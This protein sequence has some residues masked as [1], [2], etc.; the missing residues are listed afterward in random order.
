M[1]ISKFNYK[2][3]NREILNDN[4]RYYVTP[5]GEQVP[6]VTTILDR[7]KP[8]EARQALAEWRKRV[9]QDKAQ[10]ITTEAANRG[11]RMHKWLENY[12]QTGVLGIP[13]TH[14]ESQRS[15]RMAM[16]IIESGLKNVSEIWGN[17]VSL[18]F[19]ELYAG[20]TD[21]VGIHAGD[22]AILDFKQSNKPKRREWIDD[23]FLQLTAYALAH[24]EVHGTNI[25]K[26]V[27]MMAVSLPRGD[28]PEYQEFVLEPTDFDMWTQ[29][30]CD[31]VSEYYR[32]R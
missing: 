5:T 16:K 20:T 8:A 12:V 29:R 7:T 32:I 31:R 6:S 24:N 18:Y 21:C 28:E 30:W 13:G 15:H 4:R 25:R 27:V 19:P 22:E 23:Y 1:L 14:P 2:K 11:T 9:G 10:Q 17:E 26:G 3:I